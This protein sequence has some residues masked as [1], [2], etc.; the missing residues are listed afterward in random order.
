[1][2]EAVA[3]FVILTVL[4]LAPLWVCYRMLFSQRTR[5][6]LTALLLHDTIKGLIKGM[7]WL[8][9]GV[10]SLLVSLFYGVKSI[11]GP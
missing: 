6:H 2:V 4:L 5:E 7:A 3:L 9:K 1:M 10:F 8:I 11:F